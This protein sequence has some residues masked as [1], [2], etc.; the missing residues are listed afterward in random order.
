MPVALDE[1]GPGAH[2]GCQVRRQRE[3]GNDVDFALDHCVTSNDIF[4]K[5]GGGGLWPGARLMLPKFGRTRHSVMQAHVQR[6][7]ARSLE[8]MVSHH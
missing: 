3:V 7:G 6:Q 8:R 2:H 5:R 1:L 4:G